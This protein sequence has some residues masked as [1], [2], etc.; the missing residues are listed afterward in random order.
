MPE[1]GTSTPKDT[2][3]QDLRDACATEG[4]WRQYTV[5]SWEGLPLTLTVKLISIGSGNSRC[6]N[7]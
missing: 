5:A 3:T 2:P 6:C 7:K 4:P 1:D